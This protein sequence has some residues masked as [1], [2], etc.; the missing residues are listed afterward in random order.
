MNNLTPVPIEQFRSL[1]GDL[2]QGKI[3]SIE[4]T[5]EVSNGELRYK[6]DECGRLLQ[7]TFGEKEEEI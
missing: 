7:I 1:M 2:L 5:T 3:T 6:L 4:I